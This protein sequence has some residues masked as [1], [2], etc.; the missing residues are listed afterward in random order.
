M[1]INVSETIR[2]WDNQRIENPMW[3]YI[4]LKSVILE[5]S[6]CICEGWCKC[7]WLGQMG[8]TVLYLTG[9]CERFP[10]LA[11]GFREQKAFV[12]GTMC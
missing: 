1:F 9:T 10:G 12:L 6:W 8:M 3:I 4:R 5:Q 7:V 2:H 11:K